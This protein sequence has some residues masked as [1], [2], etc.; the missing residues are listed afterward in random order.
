[1]KASMNEEEK[2][3][4]T[5][6]KSRKIRNLFRRSCNLMPRTQSL[7]ICEVAREAPLDVYSIF[8]IP[9]WL[10]QDERILFISYLSS[11]GLLFVCKEK[12][13]T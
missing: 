10:V 3:K 4:Y 1:M 9:S 2:P 5:P 13:G 8:N 7:N 11:D 6:G 12:R